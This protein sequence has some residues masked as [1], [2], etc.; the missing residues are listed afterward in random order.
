MRGVARLVVFWWIPALLAGCIFTGGAPGVTDPDGGASN[1]ATATNNGTTATNNPTSSTNNGTVVATNNGTVIATNNGTVVGTNNQTSETCRAYQTFANAVCTQGSMCGEA[2]TPPD[3]AAITCDCRVS[4]TCENRICHHGLVEVVDPAT[5]SFGFDVDANLDGEV[6]VGAPGSRS[7]FVI[8]ADGTSSPL[9]FPADIVS[10]GAS[11]ALNRTHAIVGAPE[12]DS[13][14]GG[15][16]FWSRDANGRWLTPQFE[17]PPGGTDGRFG[18]SVDMAEVSRGVAAVGASLAGRVVVY[19]LMNDTWRNTRII[20]AEL[21]NLAAAGFG[22]DVSLDGGGVRLAVGAPGINTVFV[23][24]RNDAGWTLGAT[25]PRATVD[26][27]GRRVELSGNARRLAVSSSEGNER[28]LLFE[29]TGDQWQLVQ[30]LRAPVVGSAFGHD[31]SISGQFLAIGAPAGVS[32]SVRLWA[33]YA[34]GPRF[35]MGYLANP[36]APGF[37]SAVSVVNNI[38]AVGHGP[39]T[40]VQIYHLRALPIPQ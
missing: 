17:S 13:G 31:I 25:I 27:F 18:A 39:S 12:T 9:T 15:V 7:A 24:N 6:L 37:G 30:E 34:G 10:A 20:G 28:V 4:D 5:A 21:P 2:P 1:N 16:L 38:L 29:L 36:A 26:G 19:E 22:A 11:V 14:K 23:F 3:C 33:W 8:A 40:G 35:E 32:P